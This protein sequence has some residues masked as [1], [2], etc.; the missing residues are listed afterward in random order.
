[1][2]DGAGGKRC[3]RVGGVTV[4]RGGQGGLHIPAPFPHPPVDL[5]RLPDSGATLSPP[6]P[7]Y[8]KTHTATAPALS[9]RYFRK[10]CMV[11]TMIVSHLEVGFFDF[12]L[13]WR[14]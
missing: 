9:V 3:E 14:K 6:P 8:P 2:G 11:F 12:K 7:P 5:V 10:F 13:F 4:V 1:M